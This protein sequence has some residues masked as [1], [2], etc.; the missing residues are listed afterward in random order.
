MRL[1]SPPLPLSFADAC[2]ASRS[3]ASYEHSERPSAASHASVSHEGIIIDA[4]QIILITRSHLAQRA[5]AD[6]A[7]DVV[8]DFGVDKANL[9]HAARRAAQSLV[10][11]L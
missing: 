3:V 1:T 4:A 7:R 6:A 5:H 2:Q 10:L 9:T 11:S 8:R